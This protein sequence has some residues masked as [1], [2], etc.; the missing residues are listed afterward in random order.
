MIVIRGR[1]HKN[2]TADVFFALTGQTVN[3]NL[4][5]AHTL[6]DF[7]RVSYGG[8]WV[9][10]GVEREFFVF[11]FVLPYVGYNLLLRGAVVK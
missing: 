10:Y 9:G 6:Q 8:V 7:Y 3:R 5:H 11:C 4:P 2:I 1:E